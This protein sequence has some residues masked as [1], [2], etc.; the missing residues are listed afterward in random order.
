LIT[1]GLDIQ[2][3][4]QQHVFSV[5]YRL[6]Y[7]FPSQSFQSFHI[8]DT[9]FTPIR[10]WLVQ[11]FQTSG[12]RMAQPLA[13]L[14]GYPPEGPPIP[15][16]EKVVRTKDRH[17]PGTGRRD[18]EKRQGRGPSNWGDPIGDVIA[19]EADFDGSEDEAEAVPD[20]PPAE[21]QPASD[22]FAGSE[23]SPEFV[24]PVKKRLRVPSDL[25]SLVKAGDDVE[26]VPDDRPYRLQKKPKPKPPPK[27]PAA[28]SPPEEEDAS[29]DSPAP[30]VDEGRPGK[31]PKRDQA[32]TGAQHNRERPSPRPQVRTDH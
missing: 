27:A 23:D 1:S 9:R 8:S 28:A 4:D 29:D 10:L 18:R 14:D 3:P 31:K 30:P 21:F 20:D 22:V 32:F 17:E 25:T 12:G 2:F 24:P 5:R 6:L 7:P 19:A 26:I 16:R 13:S 11:L 15:E